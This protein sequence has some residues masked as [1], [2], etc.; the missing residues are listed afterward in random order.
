[1]EWQQVSSGYHHEQLQKRLS[2]CHRAFT[3]DYR[4]LSWKMLL[5]SQQM[6]RHAEAFLTL[7]LEKSD[8]HRIDYV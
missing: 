7:I 5:N 3:Q 2:N 8:L 4:S 6:A 1:M